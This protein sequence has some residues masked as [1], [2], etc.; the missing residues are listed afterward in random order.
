MSAQDV[1][2]AAAFCTWSDPAPR[3][4]G[5]PLDEVPD[6]VDVVLLLVDE[7][8]EVPKNLVDLVHVRVDVPQLGLAFSH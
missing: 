3:A 2:F 4:R 7:R 8:R 5:T 6:F 1:W